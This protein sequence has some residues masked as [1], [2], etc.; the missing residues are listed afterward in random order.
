M[1]LPFPSGWAGGWEIE[2]DYEGACYSLCSTAPDCQSCLELDAAGGAAVCMKPSSASSVCIED[3]VCEAELIC[4]APLACN[5]FTWVRA[6]GK[7]VYL[8]VSF[9]GQIYP[10]CYHRCVRDGCD[11]DSFCDFITGCL[12][13]RQLWDRCDRD[14]C[15][16]E[17]ACAEGLHCLENGMVNEARCTEDCTGRDIGASCANGAGVCGES[18]VFPGLG[19][20]D[21]PQIVRQCM[22]PCTSAEDCW[23]EDTYEPRA[24]A[25]AS[26][27]AGPSTKVC[28]EDQKW[29][30]PCLVDEECAYGPC[31]KGDE[32]WGRCPYRG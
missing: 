25:C 29:A 22:R 14:T 30:G 23:V 15:P 24:Y 2:E 6:G 4:E 12:P 31:V 32:W 5:G 18:L 16:P 21:V 1:C 11:N 27:L 8:N 26:D 3:A 7:D 17:A 20:D 13:R 9:D 19:H 28:V 10:A